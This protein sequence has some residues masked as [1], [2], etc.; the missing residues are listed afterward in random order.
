[1]NHSSCLH[2]NWKPKRRRQPAIPASHSH[3]RFAA[4]DFHSSRICMS[5][6]V[7][8]PQQSESVFYG[9]RKWNPSRLRGMGECG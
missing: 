1:M 5:A 7:L 8:Y 3:G 4:E 9:K 6:M 2:S